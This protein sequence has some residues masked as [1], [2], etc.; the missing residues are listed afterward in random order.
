[1]HELDGVLDRHDQARPLGVHHADHRR[2]RRRPSGPARPGHE[3][4]PLRGSGEVR[5]RRREAEILKRP[6]RGRDD[7]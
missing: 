3:H 5:D 4:E 6:D 7:A 1:M 2:E